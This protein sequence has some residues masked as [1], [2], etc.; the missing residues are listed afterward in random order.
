MKSDEKPGSA[1][2]GGNTNDHN[3][4]PRLI[5]ITSNESL[6]VCGT[7]SFD[8]QVACPFNNC[9]GVVERP[10]Y[11]GFPRLSRQP[12]RACFRA[13]RANI[14]AREVVRPHAGACIKRFIGV[15]KQRGP[16]PVHRAVM[17]R[18]AVSR[19]HTV[20]FGDSFWDHRGVV[21]LARR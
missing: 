19:L 7:V 11:S 12:R 10:D 4:E 14:D 17:V 13:L 18:R 15:G 3:G 20:S 2:R 16:R 1:I 5:L 9:T 8:T 21:N 6:F